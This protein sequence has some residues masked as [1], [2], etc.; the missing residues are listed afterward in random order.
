MGDV[1]GLGQV[2]EDDSEGKI[3]ASIFLGVSTRR[4]RQRRVNSLVL[5]SLNNSHGL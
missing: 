1:P 2:V 5:V 4:V 3:R